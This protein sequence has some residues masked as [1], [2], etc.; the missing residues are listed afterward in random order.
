LADVDERFFDEHITRNVKGPLFLTKAAAPLLSDGA[1]IHSNLNFSNY[2]SNIGGR[3][4]FI[5]TSLTKASLVLPNALAYV[6]SKGAIEQISRV[7]AK[8]LG[9]R[10]ITVNTVS[11]GPVDTPLFREGKTEQQI[12]F[13]ANF[14]PSKRLGQPEEIA[15]TI[16]F[17]ASPAATWINGQNIMVNGVC[18]PFPYL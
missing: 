6:A 1:F 7:L 3:V 2:S 12:Q 14:N 8:D 17:L 18:N 13:I 15:P 4:I 16:A 5:S 10:G 11:P 9:S